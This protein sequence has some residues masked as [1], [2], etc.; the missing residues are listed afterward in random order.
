[1][2]MRML[3]LALL[4]AVALAAGG[5]LSFDGEQ[6]QARERNPDDLFYNYYAPPCPWSGTGAQLYVAPRPT[7]PYVGHTFIT[8]QPLMPHEFLYH[9]HRVYWRY[10]EGSGWTRTSV[11]WQ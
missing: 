11:T 8:Y 2:A 6:A 7:P 3:R 1:M 5:L 10:N 9:H 4:V